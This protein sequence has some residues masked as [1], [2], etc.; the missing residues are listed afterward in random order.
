MKERVCGLEVLPLNRELNQ[1][2]G[3]CKISNQSKPIN[4]KNCDFDLVQFD[5]IDLTILYDL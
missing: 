2:V 4:F 1:Y 3:F 5:F